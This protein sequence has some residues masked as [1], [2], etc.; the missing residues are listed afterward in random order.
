[1]RPPPR[2]LLSGPAR[3]ADLHELAIGAVLGHRWARA[4][5]WMAHVTMR[6]ACGRSVSAPPVRRRARSCRSDGAGVAN[7]ARHP[8]ADPPWSQG[9]CRVSRRAPLAAHARARVCARPTPRPCTCSFSLSLVCFD[10]PRRVTGSTDDSSQLAARSV[11]KTCP[12]RLSRLVSSRLVLPRLLVSL[13]RS[14]FLRAV[15]GR[16]WRK[17]EAERQ[18][19]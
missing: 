10:R 7:A 6:R 17:E 12:L 15:G 14:R 13:S 5:A 8:Y 18:G 19:R 16:R 1:M 4:R 2:P 3:R 11:A 9:A